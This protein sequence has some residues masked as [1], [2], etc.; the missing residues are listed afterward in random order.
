MIIVDWLGSP[1]NIKHAALHSIGKN[2]NLFYTFLPWSATTI[3]VS[4]FSVKFSNLHLFRF[5]FSWHSTKTILITSAPTS[6]SLN[7]MINFLT[8]Q[9]I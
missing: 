6:T 7:P 1:V 2:N 5:D 4:P 9:L 3:S 8:S